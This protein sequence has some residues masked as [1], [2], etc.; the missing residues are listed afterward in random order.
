MNT[1]N[2]TCKPEKYNVAI[3]VSTRVERSEVDD[4]MYRVAKKM[5]D[6]QLFGSV[7]LTLS[8]T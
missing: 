4:P 3:Y 7:R 6:N 8:L 2:S 1:K 5:Y